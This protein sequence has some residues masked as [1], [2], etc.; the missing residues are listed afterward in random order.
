[1]HSL[2]TIGPGTYEELRNLIERAVIRSDNG[3]LPN[4]LSA[5]QANLD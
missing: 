5:Q 2:N 1:M 4:P 3:V